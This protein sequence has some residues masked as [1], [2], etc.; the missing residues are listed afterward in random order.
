MQVADSVLDQPLVYSVRIIE[1]A[2]T[3][4]DWPKTRLLFGI[5]SSTSPLS[6]IIC[7]EKT[8]LKS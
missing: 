6:R 5:L 7:G 3:R 4:F 1:P 8:A 2:S